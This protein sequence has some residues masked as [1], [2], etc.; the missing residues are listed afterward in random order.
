MTFTKAVLAATLLVVCPTL[1][2]AM[3]QYGKHE[4]VTMSCVEGSVYDPE[5]RTCVQS[6]S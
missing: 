2:T 5:T 4:E 1:A 6:T 3:C